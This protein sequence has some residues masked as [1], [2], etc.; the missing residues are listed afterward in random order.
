MT[1]VL[2]KMQ[3]ITKEFPHKKDHFMN[4]FQRQR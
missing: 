2:L 4:L 1:N 3:G